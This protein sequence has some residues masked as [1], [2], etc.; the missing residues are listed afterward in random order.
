MARNYKKPGVV[1]DFTN[2]TGSPIV[3]GQLLKVGAIAAIALGDIAVDATGSVQ[4]DE[5]FTVPKVTADVLAV[6]T[7]V[8]VDPVNKR[9]T[10]AANDGGDP[11]VTYIRAGVAV[12]AA[13]NGATFV[14]IKLNA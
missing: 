12:T 1:I 9:V 6:G 10:L 13:G 5:V 14:D 3:S 7:A 11:V 4:I 8:N 2:N